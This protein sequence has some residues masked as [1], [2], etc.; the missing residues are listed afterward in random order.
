MELKLE[1]WGYEFK[2][3]KLNLSVLVLS[4]SLYRFIFLLGRFC[5]CSLVVAKE[6]TIHCGTG[7]ICLFNVHW[8]CLANEITAVLKSLSLEFFF[9][10][11]SPIYFNVEY[12]YP[13]NQLLGFW[14]T[15]AF[16]CSF[17]LLPIEGAMHLLVLKVTT[18]P[19]RLYL[20]DCLQE[21]QEI[22]SVSAQT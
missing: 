5:G 19:V 3:H 13:P 4:P 7:I 14:I 1:P 21:P 9:L 18:E 8:Y 10:Y 2:T 12:M 22:Q 16:W 11:H 20:Q 15:R 17:S 6:R